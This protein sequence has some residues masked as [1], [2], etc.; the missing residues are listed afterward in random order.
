MSRFTAFVCVLCVICSGCSKKSNTT[1][2]GDT[3]N[4]GEWNLDHITKQTISVAP[5]SALKDSSTGLVFQFPDGGSGTLE[6][7]EITSSVNAPVPGNGYYIDYNQSSKINLLITPKETETVLVYGY[8]TSN[9]L[10][11]D[12]SNRDNTWVSIPPVKQSDG[13]MAF[14]LVMPITVYSGKVLSTSEKGYQGFKHY[15]VGLITKDMPDF[16]KLTA[17]QGVAR[18]MIK[19]YIDALPSSKQTEVRANIDGDMAW[20]LS[21]GNDLYDPYLLN[22]P[23]KT[24]MS[25]SITI[26]QSHIDPEEIAGSIAHETGHYMYHV[27]VGNSVFYKVFN[28]QP[29]FTSKHGLGD[30]YDRKSMFVEE[31]AYFSEYFH[32]GHVGQNQQID[33]TNPRFFMYNSSTIPSK[34]DAPSIEGFGCAMLAALHRT[35]DSIADVY[36]EKNPKLRSVPVIDAPFSESFQILA[37][38]P[39]D[40]DM[41][42]DKIETYL[43]GAGKGDLFQPLMQGIGWGYM[44]TGKLIDK[45]GNP[46]SGATVRSIHKSNLK[47]WLGSVTTAASGSDGSFSLP[48]GVFGGRSYLRVIK[49]ADSTDVDITIDWKQATNVKKDVGTLTVDFTPIV[50]AQLRK[51]NQVTARLSVWKV[52]KAK[53]DGYDEWLDV[54]VNNV[55]WNGLSFSGEQDD[56]DLTPVAGAYAKHNE[57]NGRM[58]EDGKT[59]EM[60]YFHGRWKE[61]FGYIT[62]WSRVTAENMP[63]VTINYQ[64]PT[65]SF[66]LTSDVMAHVSQ[67]EY[68]YYEEYGPIHEYPG[69]INW[70]HENTY[71]SVE[72]NLYQ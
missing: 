12:Y 5:G 19:S 24:I 21:F 42:R 55:K 8:G 58:S 31:S 14:E 26:S 59:I 40:I 57:V 66:K 39:T 63:M 47:E 35:E 11:S 43:M 52:S 41:L 28:Q 38:L 23:L 16:D 70:N 22:T 65:V 17:Y 64:W 53:P 45:D 67:Y 51:T 54:T 68:N 33:P 9:A 49:G 10:M 46:V 13:S 69:T 60:I 15:W 48:S 37:K 30:H 27:L 44:V 2:P 29:L 34:V 6:M 61:E 32:N 72:F 7:A 36:P 56:T 50:L 1:G 18:T 4:T 25:Y 20:N 62:A 71:V 3:D